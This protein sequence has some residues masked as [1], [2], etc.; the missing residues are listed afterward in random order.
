MAKNQKGKGKK[1]KAVELQ[2]NPASHSEP[3]SKKSNPIVQ[4]QEE[5][6][7]RGGQ[8]LLSAKEKQE[9][10]EAAR[11]EFQEEIGISRHKRRKTDN[12]EVYSNNGSQWQYLQHRNFSLGVKVWAI[13]QDINS[14][15]LVLSLSGGAKGFAPIDK[16]GS[17][18]Q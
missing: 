17:T 10:K 13:I 5:D 4:I 8:D 18:I 7:P 2:P 12:N 15:G 6:F 11:K 9:I 16:V 3:Q 14:Y 1:R